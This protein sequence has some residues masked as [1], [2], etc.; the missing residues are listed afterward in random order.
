MSAV[1]CLRSWKTAS[2]GCSHIHGDMNSHRRHRDKSL[3]MKVTFCDKMFV[4]I[5]ILNF[6][7]Y[8]HVNFS[9][10]LYNLTSVFFN[11]SQKIFN[12]SQKMGEKGYDV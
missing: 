6:M 11:T 7:I 12:T 8:L 9:L 5:L 4:G 3:K 2:S 10:L 1:F